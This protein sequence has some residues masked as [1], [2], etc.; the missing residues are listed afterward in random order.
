MIGE[1]RRHFRDHGWAVKVPRRLK[2]LQKQLTQAG[3]ELSQRL[4]RAPTASEIAEHLG[5]DRELVVEGVIA[6]SSYATRSTDV[7]AGQD[8]DYRP[9]GETLGELD[10]SLDMVIDVATVRPHIAALPDRQRTVLMLRFLENLTQTQIAERIGCS[11]M[12]VSRLLAQ[13]LR[14]LRS[15]LRE[16]ELA[17][18]A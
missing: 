5:I 17:V 18:T 1:V 3:G 15:R 4:G 11:Q 7:Q 14:T 6:A 9:L 2:D 10:P 13:A 8:D 16:P 12:H